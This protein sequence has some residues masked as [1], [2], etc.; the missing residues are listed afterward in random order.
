MYHSIQCVMIVRI[1][2]FVRFAPKYRQQYCRIEWREK[3]N[4]YASIVCIHNIIH[5]KSGN[6]QLWRDRN[7]L[8]LIY[9]NQVVS[10][11]NN[12]NLFTDFLLCCYFT[13]CS[14]LSVSLFFSSFVTLFVFSTFSLFWSDFFL[15]WAQHIWVEF[16]PCLICSQAEYEHTKTTNTNTKKISHRVK[17]MYE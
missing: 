14:L 12:R 4:V 15:H 1:G 17:V 10:Y 11:G 7:F 2:V 8:P 6:I 3:E 9:D 13:P 16:I 5:I